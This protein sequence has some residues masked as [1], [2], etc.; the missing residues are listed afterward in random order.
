M[1]L[2][3]VAAFVI[4]CPLLVGCDRFYQGFL[5]RLQNDS[6]RTL[7]AATKIPDQITQPC[8]IAP[9]ETYLMAVGSSLDL[10]GDGR[11][12]DYA[13]Q[14]RGGATTLACSPL[15]AFAPDVETWKILPNGNIECAGDNSAQ[16]Q[17]PKG[18]PLLPK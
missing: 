7:T 12:W 2:R 8:T 9:G 4:V 3:H 6:G 1:K 15:H 14:N 17:Q 13:F 16:C 18:F 5:I 10:S 11:V